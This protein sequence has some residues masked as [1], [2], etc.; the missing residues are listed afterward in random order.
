MEIK[1][2]TK[3]LLAVSF[4]T[5]Y[6][7]PQSDI[8]AVETSLRSAFPDHSFYRAWTSSVLRKRLEKE[9]EHIFSVEGALECMASEGV[10]EVV[11][12]PTHMLYGEEYRRTEETV[13][14]YAG[15]F[16]RLSVGAPLLND[17]KDVAR[18]TGILEKEY[19]IQEG[20]LLALMGHGSA[21]MS[22]PVYELMQKQFILDGYKQVCIG[23]VEFDPGIE[24]VL[25]RI[26]REKP[27]RVHLVPLLVSVGGHVIKDMAGDGEDSWKNQILREGTEVECHMTGLG[28]VEAVREMYIRH[29]ECA[30][31]ITEDVSK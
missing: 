15:R 5:A 8:T 26:R 20:E 19:T 23:T 22:L 4:G 16:T 31:A 14:S 9:G 29:A 18:L 30:R 13:R 7:G 21:N 10:K 25:A 2:G 3:A 11:V 17:E 1:N 28:K 6:S 12:Q 24:P 27:K